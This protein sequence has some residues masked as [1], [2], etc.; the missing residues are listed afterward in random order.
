MLLAGAFTLDYRSSVEKILY[1]DLDGTIVHNEFGAV[2]SRLGHGHLERCIRSAGFER[3]VCVANVCSIVSALKEIGR[4]VDGP[5]M[6]LQLCPG[7]IEDESWFRA[8]V[9]LIPDGSRRVRYI[10]FDG[11]WWWVDDR[12]LYF[13]ERE[14]LAHL[15]HENQGRRLMIPR[16]DG[17]GA[18]VLEWLESVA[19]PNG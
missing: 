7:A 12:A 8:V 13:L 5:G 19:R 9:S 10:D 2:K 17:D 4:E 14:G 16:P 3:L 18:D 15:G 1:F 6:I 11:D